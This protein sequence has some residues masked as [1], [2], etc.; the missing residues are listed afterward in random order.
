MPFLFFSQVEIQDERSQHQNKA[1]ALRV[2][3]ARV[4]DNVDRQRARER[5][6]TVAGVSSGWGPFSGKSSLCSRQAGSRIGGEDDQGM[7]R[8]SFSPSSFPFHGAD[9]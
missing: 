9:S 5:R 3:A 6:D 8:S 2:L 4:Q 7:L 1:K